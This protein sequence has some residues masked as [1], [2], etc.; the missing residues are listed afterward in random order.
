MV[1][2]EGGA[3]AAE[4]LL[5]SAEDALGQ[6]RLEISNALLEIEKKK[7]ELRI[8][9]ENM[10]KAERRME[11]AIIDAAAFGVDSLDVV[12]TAI[13]EVKDAIGAGKERMPSSPENA[14][15]M[16]LCEKQDLES[17]V[18]LAMSKVSALEEVVA[19]QK[20][21]FE[22]LAQAR[23]SSQKDL[24]DVGS[25]LSRL[26]SQVVVLGLSDMSTIRVA[27]RKAEAGVDVA[28][29]AL[30]GKDRPTRIDMASIERIAPLV[31]SA[32]DLVEDAES[33]VQAEAAAKS[34]EDRVLPGLLSRLA[35]TVD[36][37][38][39]MDARVEV[40]SIRRYARVAEVLV[41]ASAA[42][43]KANGLVDRR[44]TSRLRLGADN[45][46]LEACVSAVA[47]AEDLV[48]VAQEAI[49]TQMEIK[50]R[51]DATLRSVEKS[52]E[53]V[54][55]KVHNVETLSV[56]MEIEG[57]PA[58]VEALRKA[59]KAARECQKLYDDAVRNV[60]TPTDD[61][62]DGDQCADDVA[63]LEERVQGALDL[64][65]EAE[66][67]L[68]R[69]KKR[70]DEMKR[71]NIEREKI[72]RQKEEQAAKEAKEAQ[73]R[74]MKI[75]EKL[76]TELQPAIMSL[77][78]LRAV[79]EVEGLCKQ[80][81]T[82]DKAIEGALSA[83]NNAERLLMDES[84][85][86]SVRGAVT[87]ALSCVVEAERTTRHA[88]ERLAER[89]A[90]RAA[91]R[92]NERNLEKVARKFAR[93]KA[94]ALELPDQY[95]DSE[96]GSSV[97][98]ALTAAQVSIVGSK[99]LLSQISDVVSTGMDAEEFSRSRRGNSLALPVLSMT[100]VESAISKAGFDVDVAIEA[101]ESHLQRLESERKLQSKLDVQKRRVDRALSRLKVDERRLRSIETV[102]TSQ[103]AVHAKRIDADASLAKAFT[104][105]RAAIDEAR[106]ALASM[107]ERANAMP[108]LAAA[109][110]GR[111][112][113]VIRASLEPQTMDDY[114]K[115]SNQRRRSSRVIRFAK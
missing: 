115:Y 22:A 7:E 31:A 69:E 89:K 5:Q 67:A 83:V 29:A 82:V 85:I 14:G 15:H 57:E 1:A 105:I 110:A 34:E 20:V 9:I 84:A 66:V 95:T 76:R 59:E 58:V 91:M 12:R 17:V 53:D 92:S 111:L 68:H 46:A 3:S 23:A 24:D 36:E 16:I 4:K 79:V 81:S 32:R 87:A 75:K 107:K 99:E 11:D 8:A 33:I 26:V 109:I 45:D 93:A 98:K 42:V 103:K 80:S 43:E 63:T 113:A 38:G 37:L 104:S 6:A 70:V 114:R 102:T 78:A 41:S 39:A 65:H 40:A 13:R 64:V 101:V 25:R 61:A 10:R 97:K 62:I 21:A 30:R 96:E 47:A 100:A 86:D 88:R 71:L 112:G 73:E 44:Q 56:V 2:R 27:T 19:E 74:R 55:G 28:R 94:R 52:L 49:A 77:G 72:R 51:I 35:A 48:A 108:S 54:K 60:G 18:G 90:K 106:G 50:E